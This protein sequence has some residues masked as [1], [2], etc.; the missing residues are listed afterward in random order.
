MNKPPSNPTPKAAGSGAY[1]RMTP[2]DSATWAHLLATFR[3]KPADV[4]FAAT[5]CH[6]EVR[7]AQKAWQRGWPG[8]YPPIREALLDEQ[9]QGRAL[10]EREGAERAKDI[11]I[12]A[13]VEETTRLREAQAGA[14]KGRKEEAQVIT[15]ARANVLL[16]LNASTKIVNALGL[17]GD[18]V[19]QSLAAGNVDAATYV[20]LLRATAQSVS[21]SVSAGQT[22]MEMERL[23]LGEPTKI[24]GLTSATARDQKEALRELEETV[25]ALRAAEARPSISPIQLGD[26]AVTVEPDPGI[27]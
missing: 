26:G 27:V 15:F 13:A 5:E 22:V 1:N 25:E 9:T 17:I 18:K 24:L 19:A 20:K 23:H 2:I 6:V 3:E 4:G 14:I 7:I 10:A 12:Q 16:A 11:R 8:S 21:A